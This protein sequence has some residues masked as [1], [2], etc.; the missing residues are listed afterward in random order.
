MRL[1]V[2]DMIYCIDDSIENLTKDKPY[3]IINTRT[4][5]TNDICIKGDDGI[6]WWFGQIGE[7]ECWTN[8]FLSEKEWLR[9]KKLKEL[10]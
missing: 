7:T 6:N 10:L 8:W 9:D 5:N 3:L 2:G 1:M 4:F